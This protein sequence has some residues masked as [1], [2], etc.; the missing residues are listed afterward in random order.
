MSSTSVILVDKQDN[1]V[2]TIEKLAAH[3]QGLLHRAFSILIFNSKM[4]MLIHK[5]AENKYHSGGLWTNACCSHPL[6]DE[7]VID[8]GKRRLIEEMGIE[9]ELKPLYHFIYR[10]ELDNDLIEHEL[11]HVL[12]GFSDDQPAANE[13]EVSDWK[14]T[15]V[16]KI[17]KDMEENGENY[18]FWFK[19]IINKLDEHIEQIHSD[20]SR[21]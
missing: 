2:G 19:Q 5:R 14:Y 16:D 13:K 3:Q 9:A 12:Y 20:G 8:A 21:V 6:P 1:P 7:T 11:D 17:I 4:E 18:T 10:A 15:H